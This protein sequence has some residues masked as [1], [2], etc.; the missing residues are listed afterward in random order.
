MSKKKVA[1]FVG[2]GIQTSGA[3]DSG[4]VYV[5]NGKT[6]TESGLMVPIAKWAVYYLKQS[7][8]EVITDYPKNNIN[9]VAQVRKSNSTGVDCH[10]ALHCDY[11]K[12]PTGTIPLYVSSK[13]KKLAGY[14]N[15]Y[16]M[17]YTGIKTR[18]LGKR[19]DLYELNATI[20]PA[21]IFECGSIKADLNTMQKKSKQYG[22]GIAQGIC[23]YLGVKFKG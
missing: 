23:K 14:M 21:C 3:K 15:E 13:G 7:G 18:G 8:I 6:Y 1:L 12:A 2:H 4:C 19:K 20:A 10:V 9:M 16:V 5:K 11:Y 17:K 22:K